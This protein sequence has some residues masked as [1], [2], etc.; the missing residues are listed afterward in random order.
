MD[1][2]RFEKFSLSSRAVL[3]SHRAE[4]ILSSYKQIEQRHSALQEYE[5]LRSMHC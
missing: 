5:L 4:Y 2:T 1:I 3:R